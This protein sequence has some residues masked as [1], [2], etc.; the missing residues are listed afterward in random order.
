MGPVINH[1]SIPCLTLFVGYNAA[2]MDSPVLNLDIPVID[3]RHA[4]WRPAVVA[5]LQL[6][7]NFLLVLPDRPEDI[8]SL[9]QVVHYQ[10]A[11]L[12]KWDILP[13]QE[14]VTP[15]DFVRLQLAM[16]HGD[17]VFLIEMLKRPDLRPP[18]TKR[19][20]AYCDFR[21]I[22]AVADSFEEAHEACARISRALQ[23]KMGFSVL[24]VFEWTGSDWVPIRVA[25]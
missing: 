3:G 18:Q 21:G 11:A 5:L 19:Y 23:K 24:R 25:C 4:D 10:P 1:H 12:P 15:E 22:F 6:N 13:L 20:A 17:R 8:G 2:P 7:K 9:E 16:A 14:L